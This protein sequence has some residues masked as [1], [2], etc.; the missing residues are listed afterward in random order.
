[1]D[2]EKLADEGRVAAT[3]GVAPADREGAISGYFVIQ[4][5]SYEEALRIANESPHVQ[6][7]GVVEVRRIEETAGHAR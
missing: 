2:G 3:T 7:G 5:D 1:V 6:H 4:A